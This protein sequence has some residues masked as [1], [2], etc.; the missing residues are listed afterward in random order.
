MMKKILLLFIIF[1]IMTSCSAREIEET[2][3]VISEV[4]TPSPTLAPT[5]T[6]RPTFMPKYDIEYT[7]F[8][9]I[10]LDDTDEMLQYIEAGYTHIDELKALYP[11]TSEYANYYEVIENLDKEVEN[12]YEALRLFI[13]DYNRTTLSNQ[14][15]T[16]T[17]IWC[18][19]KDAGFSD[20]VCA[21]IL[22]NIMAECG[23][24]SL[25]LQPYV[26][27]SGGGFY[28]ICQWSVSLY[29]EIYGATLETQLDYLLE[30]LPKQIN[31]FG[32]AYYSGFDYNTFLELTNCRDVAKA[33][34]KCYE[35]CIS[36][37]VSIRLEYAEKAYEVFAGKTI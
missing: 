13:K 2:A 18:Y 28:G 35:R 23:G 7:H 15:P 33:F 24:G 14:Y 31:T 12:T 37:H 16:A 21:G 34:A 10:D 11:N 1:L 36:Y 17:E 5:P 22:G 6:P 26:V 9:Y 29:P 20:A 4:F 27:S 3:P 25:Y 8:E 30:D 19:L 32:Y